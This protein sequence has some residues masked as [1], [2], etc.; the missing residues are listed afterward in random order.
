MNVYAPSNAKGLPVLVWIHGGGYGIG[1]GTQDL[2]TIIN[3]NN[4]S[5]VGVAIQYRLGAFGFL[6]SSE[7]KANGTVNAGLLDMQFALQWVQKNI[8]LFGGDATKV[9]ISGESAG[10]G[11]VLLLGT[12]EEGTIGTS[13]YKSVSI[14][15]I[16]TKG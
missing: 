1:D 15:G 16:S 12:A 11:A 14:C 7:V 8:A 4:N 9:T 6:S 10:G 5:F 2:S 13:L 3:A